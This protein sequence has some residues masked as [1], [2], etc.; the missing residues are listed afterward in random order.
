[1]EDNMRQN[2]KVSVPDKPD[3]AKFVLLDKPGITY[4]NTACN[5]HKGVVRIIPTS[6]Q[7]GSRPSPSR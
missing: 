1:M 6:P 5:I 3:V 7:G 4:V 2:V